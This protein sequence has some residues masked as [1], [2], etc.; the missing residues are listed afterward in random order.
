MAVIFDEV[1]ADVQA[2]Q[3]ETSAPSAP[4]PRTGQIKSE[5]LVRELER[6]AERAARLRA[7]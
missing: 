2:A 1:T 4:E 6:R 3:R 5:D 7:D